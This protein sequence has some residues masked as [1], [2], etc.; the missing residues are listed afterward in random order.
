MRDCARMWLLLLLLLPTMATAQ[1]APRA[2]DVETLD[3]I[4]A[5][6]YDIVSV[7]AG[8]T[9]D[10]ARDSTLYLPEVRFVILVD[11][12]PDEV[13]RASILDHAQFAVA[14]GESSDGFFESEIHRVTQRFD[15]MV[16]VFSTYEFGQSEDGPIMGRGINS[17]E[18][19]FDGQRW[20]IVGAAWRNETTERP[21]PEEFLP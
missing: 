16:H 18:L 17:I 15:N 3:G 10:W 12:A 20:W 14:V 5:A 2:E 1:E 21:I 13:D 11:G 6:W 7:D 9:A 8:E 19:F 4:I